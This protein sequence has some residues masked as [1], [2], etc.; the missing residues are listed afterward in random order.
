MKH[1]QFEC[2]TWMCTFETSGVVKP[3]CTAQLRDRG[4]EQAEEKQGERCQTTPCKSWSLYVRHH[5]HRLPAPLA[6]SEQQNNRVSCTLSLCLHLPPSQAPALASCPRR[7]VTCGHALGQR[8]NIGRVK[9]NNND[10]NE[11]NVFV[12]RKGLSLLLWV[13]SIQI[14]LHDI[15]EHTNL[16]TTSYPM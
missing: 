3:H 15:K 9:A 11:N 16:K 5:L 1:L 12:F 10:H 7:T 14:V 8:I 13:D 6:F 2:Y 4:C